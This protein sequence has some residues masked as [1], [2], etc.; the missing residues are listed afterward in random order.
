MP[1]CSYTGIGGTVQNTRS[2]DAGG[3]GIL[4]GKKAWVDGAEVTAQNIHV[5]RCF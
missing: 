5:Y 4:L 1:V 2:G 3:G